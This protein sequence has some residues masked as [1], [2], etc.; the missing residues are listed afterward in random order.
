MR[1]KIKIPQHGLVGPRKQITYRY[2]PFPLTR[3]HNSHGIVNSEAGLGVSTGR[4]MGDITANGGGVAYL[5]TGKVE[6][7]TRQSSEFFVENRV[8]GK[9]F[10]SNAGTNYY[11]VIRLSLKK[12]AQ[13]K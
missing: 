5:T 4:G 11:M 8:F 12:M 2:L 13:K 9:F 1:Q 3:D 6:A 7:G 10:N